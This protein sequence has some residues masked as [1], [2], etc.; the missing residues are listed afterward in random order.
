MAIDTLKSKIKYRISRSK[1]AVFTP[2]DFRDL[3]DSRQVGR[4]LRQLVVDETLIRFGQGL[5]AK[6]K[7][8]SLTG[9][10][11]PVKPLPELAVEA[12]TEKL[13]V[14]VVPSTAA[15]LYSKGQTT[16][17]PTGR[18]IAVKGRVSRKMAYDGKSIKYQYV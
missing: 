13:M 15:E 17:V 8:S 7:R 14:K 2:R 6:A 16:Q 9:N 11:I 12:L 10:L 3:S 18:L 1:G 4:V 5:Y